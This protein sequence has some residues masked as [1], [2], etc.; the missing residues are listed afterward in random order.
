MSLQ[1]SR[2]ISTE[3]DALNDKH[4]G[5]LEEDEVFLQTRLLR[6]NSY[7][8]RTS[9]ELA[10]PGTDRTKHF[11]R[12]LPVFSIQRGIKSKDGLARGN[13]REVECHC[14]ACCAM[15]RSSGDYVV[16][17]KRP[18]CHVTTP[19]LRHSFPDGKACASMAE[20]P[21]R[22]HAMITG[23]REAQRSILEQN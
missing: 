3:P 16:P 9:S 10:I 13:S 4:K 8:T 6:M 20:R 1:L 19:C 11:L 23:T 7:R 17:G 18:A 22:T 14:Q 2:R 15:C 5:I 12:S 21:S